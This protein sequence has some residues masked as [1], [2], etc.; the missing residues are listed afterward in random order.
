MT[1]LPEWMR[2]PREE[3][4]FAE[5]L[6][7]LSEAPPHTELVDGTLVFRLSPQRSWHSRV[8]TGLTLD[9]AAQAPSGVEVEREMTIRL[10]Q[11]NR[12]E[13]DVL[14]T[15]A[16]YE[17]NRTWFEPADVLLVVEVASPESAHRDRTVKLRKYAEAGIRHYWLVDEASESNQP[18]AHVYEM[19]EPTKAY[20]PVGIFRGTLEVSAPFQITVDLDSLFPGKC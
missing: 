17:R 4:W 18:V 2:P 19:D 14:A 8:V 6:D 9:L 1:A 16:P 3:G 13:P 11:R 20:T 5:D 12:P 7:L 15:S 10:D